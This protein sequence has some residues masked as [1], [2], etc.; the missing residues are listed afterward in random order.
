MATDSTGTKRSTPSPW[1]VSR[2]AWFLDL[3]VLVWLFVILWSLSVPGFDFFLLIGAGMALLLALLLWV[4]RLV[5]QII[6]WAEERAARIGRLLVSPALVA[7]AFVAACAHAPLEA[8]FALS[9]HAFDDYVASHADGTPTASNRW[10]PLEAPGRLGLYELDYAYQVGNAVI[11]YESTGAL[12]NDAG[13][14]YL[15]TGPFPEIGHS[16][17][18]APRWVHLSGP[19]YTW[20]AS[21]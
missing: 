2:W 9:R 17:F 21:W 4:L 20:T 12:F 10:I 5:M 11:L 16:G 3:V 15:P 13:F 6:D 14:A 8:R 7:A 1:V 19:W 18:E